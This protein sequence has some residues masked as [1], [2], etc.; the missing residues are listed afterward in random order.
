MYRAKIN[1]R[2]ICS[3]IVASD[4]RINRINKWKIE[5]Y[6]QN[7][8]SQFCKMILKSYFKKILFTRAKGIIV[9]EIDT[10]DYLNKIVDSMT[11]ISTLL[12]KKRNNL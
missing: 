1:I 6:V 3:Q 10:E 11:K 12:N 8:F 4:C 9:V 2:N 7:Y 5:L